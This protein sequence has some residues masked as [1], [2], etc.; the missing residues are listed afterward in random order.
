VRQQTADGRQ[1]LWRLGSKQA[2]DH[3]RQ[4]ANPAFESRGINESP[5]TRGDD[6]MLE[7][8]SRSTGYV[9]KPMLVGQV[10]T[11][12]GFSDIGSH[13]IGGTSQLKANRPPAEAVPPSYPSVEV[14][15]ERASFPVDD[16]V[17]EPTASH[18][19][20]SARTRRIRPPLSA[21]CG[22]LSDA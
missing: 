7:L 17:S 6:P 4:F 19:Q 3:S 21:V 18:G 11:P 16:Q 14:I 8:K 13:R 1:Q 5:P 15:R 9:E 20:W 10:G 22:L 12:V 2:I